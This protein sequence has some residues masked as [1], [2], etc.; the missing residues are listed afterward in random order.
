LIQTD[1]SGSRYTLIP[2]EGWKRERL[3]RMYSGFKNPLFSITATA[4]VTRVMELSEKSGLPFSHCLYFQSL[5][6]ANDTEAF[7]LRLAGSPGQP[8]IRLYDYV[9]GGSTVPAADNTFGFTWFDFEPG[10]SPES[11]SEGFGKTTQKP[12]HKQGSLFAASPKRNPDDELGIIRHTMIPWTSFSSITHPQRGDLTDAIPI[13]AFGRFTRH[14]DGRITLPVSLS[15]HHGLADG[16]HAAEYLQ[17][18]EGGV[19]N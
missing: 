14:G 3:F 5:V 10:M 9:S 12:E 18:L 13:I 8:Q 2:L 15:L 4:N 19:F 7:R 11:F 1:M 17:R 16:R 6:A